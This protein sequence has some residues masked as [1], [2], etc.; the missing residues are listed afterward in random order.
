MRCVSSNFHR[1]LKFNYKLKEYI[2]KFVDD[3]TSMIERIGTTLIPYNKIEVQEELD[4]KENT[5]D[6][7]IQLY[8][9]MSIFTYFIN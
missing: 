5:Y 7:R 3:P 1:F 4:E 6:N 2:I 9:K 8:N